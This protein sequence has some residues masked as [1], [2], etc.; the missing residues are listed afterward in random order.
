MAVEGYSNEDWI[1]QG[2]TLEGSYSPTQLF[3]AEDEIKTAAA[4]Y[5]TGI[6]F[7][8]LTILAKDATGDL[9]KWDPTATAAVTGGELRQIHVEYTNYQPEGFDITA[10][11]TAGELRQILVEYTRYQP[12]GFDINASITAGELRLLL[13]EYT[14]YQPEGFDITASITGGALT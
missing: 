7:A 4:L 3:T 11:V 10:A 5:K 12:E 9:V 8:V 6:N 13:I 2:N 1:A 14:N